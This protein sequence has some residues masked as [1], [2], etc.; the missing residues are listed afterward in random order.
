MWG[1]IVNALAI[2]AGSLIGLVF[3]KGIREQYRQTIMDAMALSI[4]LIGLISAIQTQ[5]I[6]LLVISLALGSLIGEWIKI[7]GNLNRLGLWVENKL[8]RTSNGFAKGFVTASLVYC[9]GSMAIMGSIESGL[10]GRHDILFAKSILDGVISIFFASTWGVGVL[11]SAVPILVYEGLLSLGA[12]SFAGVLTDPMIREI[13]A[14]GGVLIMAIGINQ[15]GIKQIRVG[16][17]LPAIFLP[18]VYYLVLALTGL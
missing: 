15:L 8:T 17:M 16:N 14:V 10:A 5:M 6:L 2:V 3:R 12:A 11:F 18:L 7:E 9:V 13:S 4:I 1:A